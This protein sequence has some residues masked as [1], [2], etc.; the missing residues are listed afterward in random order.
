MLC[1]LAKQ[2]LLASATFVLR[3]EELHI[4]VKVLLEHM[5]HNLRPVLQGDAQER[6]EVCH[7]SLAW[8]LKP[9]EEHPLYLMVHVLVGMEGE[10][11]AIHDHALN[12]DFQNQGLLPL[13]RRLC[14][15]PLVRD[16]A[17]FH[18]LLRVVFLTMDILDQEPWNQL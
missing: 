17:L 8:R 10:V 11:P 13:V 9:S 5:L 16:A 1:N 4:T 14:G 15:D 18:Q 7:V 3:D 2:S 6:V 12:L